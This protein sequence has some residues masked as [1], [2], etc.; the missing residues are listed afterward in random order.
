M[1]THRIAAGAALTALTL[2]GAACSADSNYDELSPGQEAP[3]DDTLGDDGLGDT[4]VG[5][6]GGT[7]GTTED[8][9]TTP[10]GQ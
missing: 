6:E 8:G 4:G 10:G 7:D 5:E 2:A 1:L 3:V 9:S